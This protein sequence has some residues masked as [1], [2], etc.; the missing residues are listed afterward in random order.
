LRA[1]LVYLPLRDVAALAQACRAINAAVNIHT[2]LFADLSFFDEYDSA[3][4]AESLAYLFRRSAQHP[5]KL[6]VD[7][8]VWIDDERQQ[9]IA[10]VKQHIHRI[11]AL[12]VVLFPLLA[13]PGETEFWYRFKRGHHLS[14]AWRDF[15]RLLTEPHPTL[16]RVSLYCSSYGRDV[17]ETFDLPQ[18]ILGGDPGRLRTLIMQRVNVPRSPEVPAFSRLE[19]LV[20]LPAPRSIDRDGLRNLFLMMPRLLR[21]E[22]DVIEYA[23]VAEERTSCVSPIEAFH[24]PLQS[25]R[26]GRASMSHLRYLLRDLDI[27]AP[28]LTHISMYND[29]NITE[30]IPAIL[31]LYPVALTFRHVYCTTTLD[32]RASLDTSAAKLQP[33]RTVKVEVYSPELSHLDGTGQLRPFFENNT[34]GDWSQLN[35][36]TLHEFHWPVDEPEEEEEMEEE[37]DNEDA[38]EHQDDETRNGDILDSQDMISQSS[39]SE[40]SSHGSEGNIWPRLTALEHL[41]IILATNDDY[42]SF[43]RDLN[44]DGTFFRGFSS[45]HALETMPNLTTLT[46]EHCLPPE[47]DCLHTS[48]HASRCTC[49]GL[50]PVSLDDVATFLE[51]L[52]TGRPRRSALSRL[53]SRLVLRGVEPID[54]DLSKSLRRLQSLAKEIVF[55]QMTPPPE[56]T[57]DLDSDHPCLVWPDNPRSV[58]NVW[59]PSLLS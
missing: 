39:A 29:E 18:G 56:A 40:P 22:L 53:L 48:G 46:I 57:F 3:P 11:S 49:A 19:E 51:R 58:R 37:E 15:C 30:W 21:L 6:A 13:P 9:Y 44:P 50:L 8:P 7:L 32:L 12:S 35:Q 26:V 41:T 5:L 33:Q 4:R 47:S 54:V 25:F 59:Y 1:I 27:L 23:I 24:S 42:E 28:S 45:L 31:A 55:E 38:D 36:M 2:D 34:I 43:A 20:Y 14:R 17:N 10:E 52:W 16:K